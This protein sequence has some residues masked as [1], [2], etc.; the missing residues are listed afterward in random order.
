MQT[1]FGHRQ[2]DHIGSDQHQG[3]GYSPQYD[4]FTPPRFQSQA[5]PSVSPFAEHPTPWETDL[6]PTTQTTWHPQQHH[7][8]QPSLEGLSRPIPRRLTT[9]HPG[10]KSV[11]DATLRAIGVSTDTTMPS[12]EAQTDRLDLLISAINQSESGK[13]DNV[14]IPDSPAS[15]NTLKENGSPDESARLTAPFMRH[16]SM[17]LQ[18]QPV[19]PPAAA[20]IESLPGLEFIAPGAGSA[21]AALSEALTQLAG[22]GDTDKSAAVVT[23]VDVLASN[24]A[25][26]QQL[27]Q[28]LEP[29]RSSS[30][31][32]QIGASIDRPISPTSAAVAAATNLQAQ[33]QERQ[34]NMYHQQQQQQQQQQQMGVADKLKMLQQFQ[35][36]MRNPLMNGTE[37]SEAATALRRAELSVKFQ[38]LQAKMAARQALLQRLQHQI[39]MQSAVQ[40]QSSPMHES[41]MLSGS[42]NGASQNL[43]MDLLQ[44]LGVKVGQPV[45]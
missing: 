22:H 24:P 42:V 43:T 14:L 8:E 17:Q 27:A 40:Q 36:Q 21:A 2:P 29:N 33:Y 9:Q 20:V 31:A 38:A 26:A 28:L 3:N 16:S 1:A 37:S 7:T 18:S 41:A 23:L 6:A 4:G 25:L 34:Q 13:E 35:A 30:Q 10:E 32:E 5:Y 39:A 12:N 44:M 45:V 11:L 15:V 19:A